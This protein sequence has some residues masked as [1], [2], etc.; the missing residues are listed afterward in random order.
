MPCSTTV[1]D[2]HLEQLKPLSPAKQSWHGTVFVY[3]DDASHARVTANNLVPLICRDD[4]QLQ[5]IAVWGTSG[6]P[7]K[8]TIVRKAY[9]DLKRQE[10][11]CPEDDLMKK[12]KFECHAWVRVT[13]PFN[14]P[15]FLQC[16]VRQ[17][18]VNSLQEAA[19]NTQQEAA[20]TLGA[21]VQ[22]K[23]E[24]MNQRD[25]VHEF[26]K[27][28]TQR[29]YLIVLNDLSTIED[30]EWIKTYFPNNQ[31]GSRLIVS[32][33]RG[34]VASL[35]AGP[36]RLVVELKQSTS[37]QI[38]YA[39]C[40][41]GTKE[42]GPSSTTISNNS[43]NSEDGKSPTHIETMENAPQESQFI[44]R[45]NKVSHIIE[46]ISNEHNQ[47]LQVIS[48]CGKGGL[49][50]TTLVKSVYQSEELRS[51]F[52]K[53]AYVTIKHPF[54]RKD[55]ISSLAK[56]L[57]DKEAV[58]CGDRTKSGDGQ[59]LTGLLKGKK[60]LIVLD[61]LSSA[62]EWDA[63]RELFPN[64]SAALDGLSS[65]NEWDA[66][67]E[68]FHNN[69]AASWIMLTTST[70]NMAR[71]CSDNHNIIKLET[72]EEK[73]ANNLFIEKNI[74]NPSSIRSL[75]VF[76]K[77]R[78]FLISER[79][80]MLRVL[81][82]E[83]TTGLNDHHLEHIVKLVH[84]K[85]LSLRYCHHIYHLPH[86]FGNLRQLETLDIKHTSII[87]L[88]R[89]IIRLRKLQYL[90]AGGTGVF[91]GNSYEEL[92]Q[93]L[94]LP[95]LLKN[96]LCLL[97]LCSAIGCVLS[98]APGLL[99]TDGNPNR[100]DVCTA[101]CCTVF[102]FVAR[103]LDTRGVFVPSGVNKLNA[104][105]TLGTVN[106]G[107]SRGKAVLQDI[108]RLTRLRKLGVAGVTQKNCQGLGSALSA[109][110][111]LE[112]LSVRS[113]K[114]PSSQE[115]LMSLSL[116]ETLKS[117]KLYGCLC[118]LPQWMNNLG[119]LMKL[120]LRYSSISDHAAAME[121]LGKLQNLSILRLRENSFTGERLCFTFDNKAFPSLKRLMLLLISDLKSVEFKVGATPKLEL[122]QFCGF[123][124]KT[125]KDFF[126]GL[127][128]LPRLKEFMLDDDTYEEG[129]LKDVQDQLARNS[130]GPI[131]KRG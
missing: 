15:E 78:P 61:G 106:I 95:K 47:Q 53:R 23:M 74:V 22:N 125:K 114:E 97:S 113:V 68:L 41:K 127:A 40:E 98:C 76:G 72:L 18:Y 71:Y 88:P 100:H 70:E 84:L 19:G 65:A 31:K 91:R 126:S 77:W 60:Y 108:R 54:S 115:N 107:R 62:N 30:W 129:F 26:N 29:S 67:R 82:L 37:D 4:P 58:E 27:H 38:I 12:S 128:S 36:E 80:R 8:T 59:R 66:I 73:D 43:N 122:L 81:D 86:S 63:I 55:L 109:L 96:R 85:Y 32:T 118:K 16:V 124:N 119:N 102:P 64:N 42:L 121:V 79:M 123:P 14:P 69:S 45:Q 10:I 103:R 117:L 101:W 50:K 44:S 52:K 94:D 90:R 120:S 46:R 9:D 20:A 75:T 56:Q 105:H 130:N 17:F 51:K 110:S 11:Q 39:F 34:E 83:G 57:G 13:H 21:Q 7:W 111:N 35:C 5:V 33:E 89:A 6:D 49:G 3:E 104:L 25:L 112:S 2:A 48:I 24:A 87:K 93:A 28:V 131:L 1:G 92:I 116:P 99:E